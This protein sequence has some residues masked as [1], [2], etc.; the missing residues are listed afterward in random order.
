M[1]VFSTLPLADVPG[2][3]DA[4]VEDRRRG[5]RPAAQRQ[6]LRFGSPLSPRELEVLRATAEGRSSKEIAFSLEPP[7][8]QGTVRNHFNAIFTR[9]G[10]ND[11]AHAVAIG[12]REG[13]IVV[14]P[15]TLSLPERLSIEE[16]AVVREIIKLWT[17]PR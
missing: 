14:G 13:Y 8:T 12:I 16:V 2:G 6:P 10:A 3:P 1:P 9:L 15:P 7:V 4:P 11:R 17:R 5:P